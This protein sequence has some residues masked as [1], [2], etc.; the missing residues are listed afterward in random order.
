M[1]LRT[2]CTRLVPPQKTWKRPNSVKRELGY[3]PRIAVDGSQPPRPP[4][5]RQHRFAP[6]LAGITSE[7]LPGIRSQSVTAFAAIS[8]RRSQ[9]CASKWRYEPRRGH[10]ADSDSYLYVKG[11]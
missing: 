2:L 5:N 8:A 7:S 1:A 4:W 9:R 10:A 6:V 11:L 3:R